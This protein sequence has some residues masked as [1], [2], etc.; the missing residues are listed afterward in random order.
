MTQKI[1]KIGNSL[2]TIMPAEVIKQYGFKKG[3][4][5]DVDYK[6]KNL[7]TN[8]STDEVVKALENVHKRYGA[9]LK[10]LANL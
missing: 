6:P 1:I 5:V 3:D 10:K 2:G 9:A 8:A 4:A 7:K